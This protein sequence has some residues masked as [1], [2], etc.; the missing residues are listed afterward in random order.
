[1]E[2]NSANALQG[3]MQRDQEAQDLITKHFS[4]LSVSKHQPASK[5]Q[6]RKH[7]RNMKHNLGV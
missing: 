4:S 2:E 1:M 3:C 6:Y 5:M 7:R